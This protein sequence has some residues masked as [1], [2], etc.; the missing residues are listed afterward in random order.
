M[1]DLSTNWIDSAPRIDLSKLPDAE[2]HGEAARRRVAKRRKSGEPYA[3]GRK[4]V[5]RPC[6]KCGVQLGAVALR[7]HL[8]KC[9]D[10]K[11][12]AK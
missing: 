2:I 11:I 8:P 6:P 5:L 10:A 4:P 3:G 1:I 9:Q 7:R 12:V